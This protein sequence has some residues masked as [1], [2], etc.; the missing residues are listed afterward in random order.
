MVQLQKL[1]KNQMITLLE[2]INREGVDNQFWDI[3]S[4]E[5]SWSLAA[6]LM[7]DLRPS[8]RFKICLITRIN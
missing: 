1:N 7:R 4:H 2:A 8:I 5:D 6:F 3:C